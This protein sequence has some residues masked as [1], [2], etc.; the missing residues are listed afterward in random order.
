MKQKKHLLLGWN[1]GSSL[2]LGSSGSIDME[3]G[4]FIYE[5]GKISDKLSEVELDKD[6]KTIY[7]EYKMELLEPFR[8][9]PLLEVLHEIGE[10]QICAT[11]DFK[12]GL[13]LR[14][15]EENGELVSRWVYEV[16]NNVEKEEE[17]C[18][19]ILNDQKDN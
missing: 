11:C 2:C 8:I 6:L 1:A 14:Y 3:K 9:Y 17:I 10:L 7:T 5:K 12:W 15:W 13:T 19:N 4:F 18:K 16:N